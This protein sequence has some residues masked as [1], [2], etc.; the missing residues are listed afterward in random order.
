MAII[1]RDNLKAFKRIK[2]SSKLNE[3]LLT[4]KYQKEFWSNISPDIRRFLDDFE[5]KE[6]WTYTY[7]E[8]PEAFQEISK[9]LPKF[10][11]HKINMDNTEKTRDIIQKI[12]VIL[13]AMPLRESISAISWLDRDISDETEIGWAVAIYMQ[14]A[15][16]ALFDKSD[17]DYKECKILYD[18][19][20]IM[21]HSRHSSLLFTQL[22][23]IG[24]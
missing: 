3:N 4:P 9:A 17:P 15:Q 14:A 23:F 12:T 11:R 8:I 16:V 20:R 7:A 21:L 5:S 1:K 2:M 10:A 19:V 6:D 13:A 18:R 24:E 22:R